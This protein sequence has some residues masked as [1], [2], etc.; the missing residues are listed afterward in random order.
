M[1]KREETSETKTRFPALTCRA[2]PLVDVRAICP[3]VV[4]TLA[5]RKLI[6]V[7]RMVGARLTSIPDNH[8]PIPVR[9]PYGG[10]AHRLS[11]HEETSLAFTILQ[12]ACCAKRDNLHTDSSD[13]NVG[14]TLVKRLSITAHR[15]RS[16]RPGFDHVT[17]S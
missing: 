17:S 9:E 10:C 1:K 16:L 14:C 13:F 8:L 12:A 2:L 15:R 11:R 3:V 7:L 4:P 5:A 6:D